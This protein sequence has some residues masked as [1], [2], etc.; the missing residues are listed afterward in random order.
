MGLPESVA[1]AGSMLVLFAV[2][3]QSAA[4]L[5]DR[6]VPFV[7]LDRFIVK[8]HHRNGLNRLLAIAVTV[9]VAI[10]TQ[11]IVAIGLLQR[12]VGAIPRVVYLFELVG[13]L[14]WAVVLAKAA[15]RRR[16]EG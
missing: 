15:G 2:M 3:S 5:L 4:S 13:A 11:G 6:Q 8:P 10:G 14:T 1:I 7:G 9:I 16:G 12:D